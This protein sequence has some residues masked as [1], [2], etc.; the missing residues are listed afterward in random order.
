MFGRVIDVHEYTIVVENLLR[1]VEASFLGVHV[2]FE[3]THKIVCEISKISDNEI[4]CTMIGEISNGSF[5]T[6]ITHKPSGNATIRVINKDEVLFLLGNQNVDTPDRIY[7]GKSLIY[8]GINVSANINNLFSNHFAIL[9]NTGSGKSCTVARLIQNLFYRRQYVPVNSSIVLFDVYGEYHSAFE[10]IN[11]QGECRYK[12]LTTNVNAPEDEIIKIPPYFLEVDDIALLL[13]ANDAVQI[14]IIEKALRYVYLFTE[15][16]AKVIQY[17]NNII[18]KAIMDILTSGKEPARIRDQVVAVLT[19]FNTA[20]INLESEIVQPGYT[21]TI[22]QCLKIDDSG[23]IN[24]IHLVIEYLEQYINKEFEL[25]NKMKPKKYNLK[26]L[27]N[28]FEFALISEGVLKSDKIYDVNNILKVRLDS[29]I[30]SPNYRYFEV[31]EYITK[32]EYIRRLF[33]SDDGK[34]VQILNFNLDYVDERF[35]KILTK[36]Y[37]KM[38]FNYAITLPKSSNFS[39]QILLEEAHRYV[40]NDKD[41][42]ILGYNVFDRITKEGRKYGVVLGLITQRPCEL[43]TTVLSQCSNYIVLRMFH[44]S[45][46]EI[47]RSITHSISEKDV[48]RI[49]SLGPGVALCFGNALNL[50]L[51]VK[52]D[53]P[54]PFPTSSNAQI[55]DSWFRNNK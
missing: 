12:S 21:R 32:E 50:P 3:D 39:I 48:N 10:K 22:R 51:Y 17:K 41:I 26:D 28:A 2:I 7:L 35:T 46:L 19:S 11:N 45:D 18:A 31:E 43:S 6:G 24:T 13:Q 40:Q 14:P 4:E 42:D 37:S 9:G 30:N 27:Y 20:N 5:I 52:I 36:L 47:I 23:K 53:P 54:N 49:K 1:K 34:K 38:F 44:P 55:K 15:E 16:E 29:I 25:N 8:D 33:T